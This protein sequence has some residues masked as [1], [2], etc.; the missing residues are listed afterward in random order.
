VKYAS[1]DSVEV[2][3]V[4]SEWVA[5]TDECT[6]STCCTAQGRDIFVGHVVLSSGSC[7]RDTAGDSAPTVP[8]VQ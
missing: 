1:V 5:D 2:C 7:S 3:E 8:G 6:Y 4:V